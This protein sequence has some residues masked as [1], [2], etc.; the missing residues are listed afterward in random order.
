[1]AKTNKGKRRGK[2]A[3]AAKAAKGDK[4]SKRAKPSKAEAIAA[5]V[6]ARTAALARAERGSAPVHLS[7]A[8]AR[9]VDRA[10]VEG[11]RLKNA[12]S[13]ALEDFGRWLLV[14]VFA[15]DATQA[16][17][18]RNKSSVW[19]DLTRRAGGPTLPID[20]YTLS[21]ALRLAAWDK[22][23]ADG[24]WRGLDVFRR[25]LLLPLGDASVMREAAQHVADLKLTHGQTRTYVTAL[26]HEQ[27]KRR[28]VRVTSRS[29]VSRVRAFRARFDSA[30]I[31]ARVS[32]LRGTLDD[33]HRAEVLKE[34]D[35]LR[36]LVDR[37]TT[38]LR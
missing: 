14:E 16:L 24:A 21:V 31:L 2:D 22:R 33:K 35:G 28:Q 38:A 7:A 25:E 8:E 29:I 32:D 37:L 3:K 23:I 9:L 6:P 12:V 15:G 10:L 11:S 18:P 27:G 34:L 30:S 5:L 36:A 19:L 1:M 4:P 17:D 13:A 20:R 26:L